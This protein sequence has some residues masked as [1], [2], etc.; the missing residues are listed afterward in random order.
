M[1]VDLPVPFAPTSAV[2]SRARISQLAS[3]NKTR[4]PNRLPAFCRESIYVYFRRAAAGRWNRRDRP[5]FLAQQPP[6]PTMRFGPGPVAQ[7]LEQ[8]THNP[9][10]G[11]S[12]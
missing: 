3:R 10:V 4:G 8:G 7:R 11:G 5:A 2:F 9:L 1:I 6:S 12:N